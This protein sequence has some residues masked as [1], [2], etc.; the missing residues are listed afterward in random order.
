MSH[1]PSGSSL[2]YILATQSGGIARYANSPRA[3][4]SALYW[5][6]TLG[7][8]FGYFCLLIGKSCAMSQSTSY[9]E[10]WENT[11]GPR[12][13]GWIVAVLNTLDPLLGIFANASI[14]SQSLQLLL[15]G[16]DVYWSV[17]ECL[18]V[19]TVLGILPL[20]LMKN[21]SALAPFSTVGMLAV[22]CALASMM[23]RYYDGSY[24]PGGTFYSDIPHHLRP[25]FG[26]VNRPFSS[27]AMPFCAMVF[28]SF[29]MHYNS[30]RF[31]AELRDASVPRFRQTVFY[32]FG[33]TAVVYFAIAVTGFLTFGEHSDTY[34]LNNYS[35]KDPLATVSR[36][37]IGMCALVSYPL[38]YIGVRDKCL[39]IL[40]I[41][42]Q[43]DTTAK[44]NAFTVCLLALLTFTSCFV[45]DLGLINSVG[46][47]T[48]VT[49]VDF[50]FPAL[51][52]R[53]GIR[54]YGRGTLGEQKE[55]WLVMTLMVVG[56]VLG[57]I[58]VWASFAAAR[59]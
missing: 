18:L 8:V 13:G 50:V 11:V 53:E 35:S 3:S 38:N 22:L 21:L 20:C 47:G 24:E 34:I 51:M 40:G 54:R 57:I 37:A 17:L 36:L 49:M 12:R 59:P 44:L 46:G 16:M 23:V 58:G 43:V 10:C 2:L 25:S 9:R 14:L 5:I 30:P 45:T 26:T 28:T 41:A 7:A 56:C 31:Y 52:F 4:F 42:E 19:V 55:V 6:M 15:E 32:A 29:D 1:A 39:D 33:L 48:T 27:D